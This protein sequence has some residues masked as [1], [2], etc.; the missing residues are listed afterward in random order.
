MLA[1]TAFALLTAAQSLSAQLPG[2][3]FTV[4]PDSGGATVGD[5]VLVRFRIRLHE[6]DQLLDSVPSV[7]GDRPLGVRIL[8]IEKLRRS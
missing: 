5:S 1:T 6:R 3:S 8:S 2:Q 4:T 7:A